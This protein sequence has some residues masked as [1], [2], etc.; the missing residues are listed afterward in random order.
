MGRRG[1][2]DVDAV[3]GE[4]Y[5]LLYE[6]HWWWRAREH[7]IMTELRR[8]KPPGGWASAL[9]VGCGDGLFFEALRGVAAEVEGVEPAADLVT[10]Q[11]RRWGRIH[12][13]PF[14]ESFVPGRRYSLVLMLDVLEHLPDA[15]RALAQALSLLEPNGLF[16]ATVPAFRALWTGHDDINHH[17]TRYTRT[18]FRGLAREAGL[19]IDSERYFFQWTCPVKLGVRCVEAMLGGEAKPASVPA[20]WINEPL[21][22]LSRVEAAL[23]RRLPMPFGSS[24]LVMGG[25]DSA[26]APCP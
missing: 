14:D 24:L 5:R 22:A 13:T 4:R 26:P 11:G 20:P 19:R 16:V 25:R 6:R 15:P 1:S 10:D 9:D 7:L 12:V 17:L 8:R 2:T 23:F 21:H 3:Y 18:T